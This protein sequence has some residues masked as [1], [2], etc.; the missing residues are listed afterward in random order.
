MTNLE[1][2]SN[3]LQKIEEIMR[4]SNTREIIN[5]Y[6]IAGFGNIEPYIR[7]ALNS[8]VSNDIQEKT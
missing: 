2:L 7:N 5:E 4:S 8:E 1:K 3:K 6:F